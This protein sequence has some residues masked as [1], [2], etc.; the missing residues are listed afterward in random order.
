[1]PA[2]GARTGSW[3]VSGEY[4]SGASGSRPPQITE[5]GEPHRGGSVAVD[6]TDNAIHANIVD[7]DRMGIVSL[8]EVR[9]VAAR[10]AHEAGERYLVGTGKASGGDMATS[11]V[12]SLARL[13]RGQ[14]PISLE[15]VL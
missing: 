12:A 2:H 11:D 7:V 9:V 13:I 5:V 1:M 8:D 10:R 15:E 3:R 4:R 14:L 6:A